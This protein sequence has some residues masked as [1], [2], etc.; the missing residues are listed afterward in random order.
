[1]DQLQMK[2]S[3]AIL[4]IFLNRPVNHKVKGITKW[5]LNTALKVG[6]L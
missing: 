6:L 3:N 5:H 1:M 4:H 2:L